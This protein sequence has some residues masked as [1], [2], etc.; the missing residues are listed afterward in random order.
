[1]SKIHTQKY[2][3]QFF[4]NKKDSIFHSLTTIICLKSMS[5]YTPLVTC[6]KSTALSKNN[7]D[8]RK[9]WANSYDTVTFYCSVQE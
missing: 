9:L 6:Q 7:P 4:L 3:S 8:A 1:V 5:V 2:Q